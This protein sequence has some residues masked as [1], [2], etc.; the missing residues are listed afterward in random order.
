[1][2]R[3]VEIELLV[4]FSPPFANTFSVVRNFMDK[5]T[6][7]QRVRNGTSNK[8]ERHFFDF[9]VSDKSLF[10]VFEAKKY[11][12]IG[13]FGWTNNFEYENSQIDEFIGVINPTLESGRSQFY[14]CSECG[15]VCCGSITAKIIFEDNIVV[16]REFGYENTID[17]IDYTLFEN[18]GPYSFDRIEYNNVFEKLRK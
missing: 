5:I 17:E 10:D 9:V 2:L 8:T 12:M 15:D 11:D 18:F 3:L 4:L 14:V 1:M 7:N 13:N 6:L 16:W